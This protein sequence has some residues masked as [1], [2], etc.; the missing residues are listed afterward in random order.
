MTDEPRTARPSDTVRQIG[1]I[2]AVVFMIVAAMIGVGLFGGTNVR[3]LQ[4][5]ALDAD[6]TLLAPARPAFSIWSAIYLLTIGYAIWQALPSQRFRERHRAAGWPVALTAVLNGLWL[7]TAQWLTLPLTVVAIALLLV[8]LGY[9][10]RV[11]QTMPGVRITGVVLLDASVGLHLGWVALATVANVTAWLTVIAPA[12][13]ADAGEL[14]AVIV[15]VVVGVIGVAI[16]WITNGR[17]APG[18]AMGWG[19][20]W[21]GVQRSTGEPASMTVAIAAWVVAFVVVA[22]PLVLTVMRARTAP[23]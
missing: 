2:A 21:I 11:L 14:I 13:W 7:L 5:G 4:G 20:F 8:A 17:L 3:E 9:T 6:A 19:L 12:E 10:L 1:V 18:L 16:A 22:V 15:L 23:D